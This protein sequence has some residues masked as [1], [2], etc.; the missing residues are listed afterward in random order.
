MDRTNEIRE[1]ISASVIGLAMFFP[2]R[3]GQ[4]AMIFAA[5]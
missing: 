1:K 3:L 4:R 5:L 2:Y